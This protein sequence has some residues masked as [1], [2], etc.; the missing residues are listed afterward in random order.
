[1]ALSNRGRGTLAA[2]V[3]W[4]PGLRFSVVIVAVAIIVGLALA[5]SEA[6]AAQL[7]QSAADS[8]LRNVEAIVRGY[9]DP[10]VHEESL[11]LDAA[12][13]SQTEDELY[14]LTVSGD[15]RRINIWSRDGR[16]VYSN[17]PELRGKRLSI[18]S[19]IATAFL[20]ESLS[21]YGT[22]PPGGDPADQLLPERYLEVFVPIR[23]RTD[24]NPIGVYDVYQDAAAIETRVDDTRRSVF[25]ASLVAASILLALLWLGFAGASRLL[26]RQNR[27]L[28]ERADSEAGL[29][30]NLRRSEER[31]RSLVRNAS[32]VILVLG[33][34]QTIT[35]E[36]PGVQRLL[37]YEPAERVG[38]PAV[39]FLHPDDLP[40]VRRLLADVAR[41]PDA[42]AQLEVRS[43]HADGSWRS[44]EAAVKNLLDDPAVGGIVV[45][46]RDITERKTLEEQ[47]RHQAFHDPLTGIPNRALFMDRLEHALT[48]SRRGGPGLAILFLDLDDFKAIN[49][50][51]G[52]AAGDHVLKTVA[53]RLGL[54]LRTSDTAARMGGDEFA[55]V[56]EDIADASEA[57]AL[58]QRVQDALRRPMAWNDDGVV[59]RASIGIAD[60]ASPEQTATQL[61]RNADLSMYVAKARGKDRIVTFEASLHDA[62]I[63]RLELKTD[64]Y[65]A[66]ERGEFC[67]FY[68]PV[69]E[70]NTG[71]ICGLEALLRWR[72]PSRGLVG[73]TEFIGLAEESGLIVPLGRW[74]LAEACR[75]ARSWQDVL[76][77]R[78]M[79]V[80]VNV[81]GRQIDDPSL[82]GDVA[83][84]LEESG[85]AA[86]HL[87][88]EITESVLME[89]VDAAVR[90]LRALKDL[91]VLIAIDDFGTG[92]SS[93]SY[94]HRF[95]VDILKIDRSFVM[96]L[97]GGDAQAALVRSILALSKSLGLEAIAEGIEQPSQL[98]QLRSFGARLGQGFYFSPA[99]DTDSMTRL[100]ATP[101][102]VTGRASRPALLVP[103]RRS[104]RPPKETARA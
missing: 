55:I 98:D 29:T 15:L 22:R 1:V 86:E 28:R 102:G 37:G 56:L 63:D 96:T 52:H 67:L 101:A 8:A 6:V 5:V 42:E 100:L 85:L 19:A 53:E 88:L 103:A 49:D 54:C 79:P 36:S 59:V 89:D 14:R 23:G 95:P 16:V 3:R 24:G 45:N 81:S 60:Y 39:E 41:R 35:Y 10:S 84:A 61:L 46:Y 32:D 68:Q 38:R 44:L 9:V 73:P 92:Y 26:E 47:L 21:Q 20:G 58:G 91:G 18:G 33:P 69:V 78:A 40:T 12:S 93:L 82:L 4:R 43:R 34:D 31:F 11:L 51:L 104:I 97:G 30:A 13:D 65:L 75:Q 64:L 7:R 74:V 25:L 17:V 2:L 90:T 83:R 77:G 87:T 76:K 71:E 80:S 70:L 72:H 62:T 99:L 50:G 27:L 66:M 94:L 57:Q 48:R